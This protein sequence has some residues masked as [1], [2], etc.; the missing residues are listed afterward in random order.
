MRVTAVRDPQTVR[1]AVNIHSRNTGIVDFAHLTLTVTH[2]LADAVEASWRLLGLTI[3][4]DD[5]AGLQLLTSGEIGPVV[6]LQASLD[7][8]GRVLSFSRYLPAGSPLVS[9]LLCGMRR[10]RVT[11]YM[12]TSPAAMQARVLFDG[13]LLSATFEG[14][15]PVAQITAQDASILYAER[16]LALDIP[17]GSGRTRLD[18]ATEILGGAAIPYSSLDFG[19]NDGGIVK[20]ALVVGGDQG[21]IEW[22]KGFLTPIGRRLRFNQLGQLEVGSFD[23]ASTPVRSLNAS[24]INNLAI[25]PPG[26][27]SANRISM[28]GTAVVLVSTALTATGDEEGTLTSGMVVSTAL[29]MGDYA[30]QVAVRVQDKDDGVITDAVVPPPAHSPIISA[31]TTATTIEF[32]LDGG[33]RVTEVVDKYGFY[34]QRAAQFHIADSAGTLEWNTIFDVY[35]FQDGS[36]RAVTTETYQHISRVTTVKDYMNGTLRGS[37]ETVGRW[38]P[39]AVSPY[40]G[41]WSSGTGVLVTA[42]REQWLA[43]GGSGGKD[44]YFDVVTQTITQHEVASDGI[45]LV[46]VFETINQFVSGSG[47][48]FSGYT[49]QNTGDPSSGQLAETLQSSSHAEQIA[50]LEKAVAD[51]QVLTAVVVDTVRRGLTTEITAFQQ[52]D[53]CENVA[54]LGTAA[55]YAAR[56]LAKKVITLDMPVDLTLE[57]GRVFTLPVP[58]VGS[59]SRPIVVGGIDW[60]IDGGTAQNSQHVTGWHYP[61]NLST[62]A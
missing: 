36:A 18:I 53:F 62:I 20:K 48:V 51:P 37:L 17:E 47:T 28:S 46:S 1:Q 16:R 13:Y 14:V 27:T 31:T 2:Q 45:H 9:D 52:N 33:V 42:Q 49:Y 44:E 3:E 24:Q 38:D 50:N 26:T 12:G 34:A 39:N 15:P 54:E 21:I 29:Q 22:L 7:Q 59:G 35:L 57:D 10:I 55:F 32:L 60:E 25:T 8:T 4:M 23:E 19:P 43:G 40:N 61:E 58:Q 41:S 56:E 5:G 11:G 6:T 30:P